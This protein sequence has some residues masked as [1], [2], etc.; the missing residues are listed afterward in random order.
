MYR[1]IR[2]YITL[3]VCVEYSI[4]ITNYVRICKIYLKKLMKG[5]NVKKSLFLCRTWRWHFMYPKS[6]LCMEEKGQ[7]LQ[8]VIRASGIGWIWNW[9]GS[10][11]SQSDVKRKFP[12][13]QMET[14]SKESRPYWLEISHI[15]YRI[16]SINFIVKYIT[17]CLNKTG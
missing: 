7:Y 5:G 3:Q 9:L 15:N 14:E 16:N 12:Y 17:V 4:L 13:I 11:N 2:L 1:K 6:E 10:T 8:S